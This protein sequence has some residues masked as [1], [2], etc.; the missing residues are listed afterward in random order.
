VSDLALSVMPVLA[1]AK[2]AIRRQGR[3]DNGA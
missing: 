2:W 3:F 1:I